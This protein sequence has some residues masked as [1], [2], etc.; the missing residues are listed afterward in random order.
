[1][2]LAVVLAVALF[3]T[4]CKSTCRQLSEKLCECT[5]NTNERTGCLQRAATAETTNPPTAEDEVACAALLDD[6]DCRLVDTQAGK[7][8]CGIARGPPDAGP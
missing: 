7:E 4:G 3:S 5:L 8:R 2:R 1:M 6:C